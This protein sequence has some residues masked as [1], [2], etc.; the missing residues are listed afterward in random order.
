MKKANCLKSIVLASI[1]M[2]SAAYAQGEPNPTAT[3]SISPVTLAL[4]LTTEG[5][6]LQKKGTDGKPVKGEVAF[7]QTYTVNGTNTYEQG[8]KAVAVKYGNKEFLTDLQ[9]LGIIPAGDLKGWTIQKVQATLPNGNLLKLGPVKFYAV[10]GT[11]VKPLVDAISLDLA[12]RVDTG[13]VKVV[14]VT[15]E[16]S[17]TKVTSSHSGNLKQAR[18]LQLNVGEDE[19]YYLSGI[20]TGTQKLGAT[21]LKAQVILSGAGKMAL[22]GFADEETIVEGSL[23]LGA[24][25]AS[26]NVLATY[27]NVLVDDEDVNAPN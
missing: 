24:G 14:T 5:P 25:V 20:Y 16:G 10:K 12:A 18:S 11:E 26:E 23:T 27:P 17:P 4:T 7:E 9:G 21:K 19:S 13:S 1:P 15:K 2:I 6:A 22:S 8:S 3:G